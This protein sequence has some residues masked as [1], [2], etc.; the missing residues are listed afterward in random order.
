MSF[1]LL[2]P[3]VIILMLFIGTGTS[4]YGHDQL[5]SSNNYMYIIIIN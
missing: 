4:M 5:T 1:L 2:G 3:T